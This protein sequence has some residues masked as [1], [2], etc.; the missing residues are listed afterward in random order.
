M[1]K[2]ANKLK[3]EATEICN[4]CKTE[5][6]SM[7]DEE[8]ARINEIKQLLDALTKVEDEVADEDVAAETDE[9]VRSDE[10]TEE[11]KIEDE[12]EEKADEEDSDAETTD[13]TEDAPAEEEEKEEEQRKFNS[14]KNIRNN[15]TLN[16]KNK[17]EKRFSLINAINGIV[18]NG[19]V[20]TA[21]QA[22]INAAREEMRKAGLSF[23]GQIQLPADTRSFTVTG[24]G[25]VHDDLVETK[26]E[27]IL[28][29][30]YAKNVLVQAGAKY[31][32]GCIGDVQVP[33]MSA[34]NVYWEAEVGDAQNGKGAVSSVKLT[35]KRLTAYVDLSKQFLAQDSLSAESLI[36]QDLVN[37]INAKLESTILG[38]EAGSDTQ[39]AGIFAGA[40]LEQIT[41][42]KGVCDFEA[43]VE[44]ANVYGECKYVMSPKAKA[45]FRNMAKSTKST[46][47]VFADGQLDGTPVLTT[48]NVAETNVAYGDFSNL[49]IAQ[50]SGL[51]LTVDPYTLATKGMVRI[52]VNAYFDAAVLRKEAI[53]VAK[54]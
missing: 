9:D 33:V 43:G 14:R 2:L 29:P 4:R 11:D 7:T 6:R 52:V 31:M 22:V 47:L 41:T 28:A 38:A 51:D 48:S 5:V 20:S 42:Y 18:K 39:P 30:L 40:E 27:D 49:A 35:P 34:G 21:D 10:E 1:K 25:G 16:I 12:V 54:A 32:T 45:A 50:W 8:I 24:E 26:F 23:N 44:E 17:M 46:E 37:A 53:A 3:A 19:T 36:R 15:K 13:E